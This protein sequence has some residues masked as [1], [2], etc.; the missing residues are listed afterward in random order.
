M[1]SDEQ[2]TT[3]LVEAARAGDPHAREE[4]VRAC[5]PLVHNVVGRALDGHADTDDVVQETLVRA[6]DG[7]PGLRDPARFRS[8]LV[9]IA[10]NG[11]RRR[12]HERRQAPVPGL[13]RAADLADPSGDFTDLTILRLGL[14]GQRRDVARATRWL[15]GEDGELLSLW[16]LE[17]AGEL[18][19]ADLAEALGLSPAH[20][21][22]RVQR[23]K[24][25][26]ETGRAVV[27]ALDTR[28]RCPEL[29]EVLAPWDGRPSPLWRKRIARHLRDCPRCGTGRRRLAPVEGL[30][31]GI[32]LVPPLAA[33]LL[34]TTAPA[35]A[36]AA[37]P[38]GWST[39]PDPAPG[40]GPHAPSGPDPA[41]GPLS[42]TAPAPGAE[43]IS[44]TAPMPGGPAPGSGPAASGTGTGPAS[45]TAPVAG[46]AG[47]FWT[48]GRRTGAAGVAAVAV[49]GA[50]VLSLPDRA[51]PPEARPAPGRPSAAPPAT[52]PAATPVPTGT[53][54]PAPATT[55]PART[56]AAPS[57]T[58]TA[59]P[60][61]P[62]ERVTALVNR[63][64]AEAGCAPLRTDPRLTAAARA[65]ARDMV[66]RDSYGHAGPGGELADA[67]ITAAG[68]R[69]SAWAENL[70]EGQPTP[71]A[72]V[73][74]WRDGAGHERNMLD[75]S[76]RDTGV[77][78][79]PGPRGPVWVQELAAP[80]G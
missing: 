53:P 19:R 76:Y 38:A 37:E 13:D 75:C 60:P 2:R 45:G 11:V 42:G 67:R 33:G 46:P 66:A 50:L 79:V 72:V 14:T 69:W 59:P 35:Q 20:A 8:W 4:L 77:A 64:R 80:L 78:T 56:A 3:A 55:P 47:P 65:Y 26:L 70:A 41:S 15:D 21:A 25:R 23:M 48:P 16:W 57:R 24:E 27:G 61:S 52:T 40:T 71:A 32:G 62:G 17:A 73:E 43:P 68:Y 18:S 29:T 54:P 7:L 39:A 58:A 44:G 31:V 6:L 5:L 12:W 63:L 28:P 9:A 74:G 51:A 30:L 36:L 10:M 22:V 1:H 49:L 34:D